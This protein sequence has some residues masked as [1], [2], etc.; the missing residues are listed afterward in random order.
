VRVGDG[1]GPTVLGWPDFTGNFFFNTLGN[2]EVNPR[3]GLLFVDFASGDVLS[4]TGQTAVV[5]RGAEVDAFD[6]AERLLR[7][8]VE[9]GVFI[10]RM[11]PLRWSAPR[12]APELEAT[13]GWR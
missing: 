4:L 11:L 2:L 6:G 13:G 1:E 8:S 3:A 9:D 5:W 7:L 10:E 12:E